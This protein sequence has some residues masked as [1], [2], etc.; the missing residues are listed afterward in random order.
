MPTGFLKTRTGT[1]VL[2]LAALALI[3]LGWQLAWAAQVFP[4]AVVP[5]PLSVAIAFAQLLGDSAFWTALGNTMLG[6]G[7]GLLVAI[8]VGIPLGMLTGR[9]WFAEKSLHFMLEFGRAFPAIAL[10]P[11]LV[12][13]IGTNNTM[14]SAVVFTAVLFPLVIQAQ[15]GARR[16]EPSIEETVRAFRI[17]R[18]KALAKIVLPSA[19]PFIATGIKLGATVSVLVALGVEVLAGVP[20]IGQELT[21]AQQSS[22][23]DFAF[24]YIFT[25]GILGFGVNAVVGLAKDRLIR[26]NAN[27]TED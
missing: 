6:A 18:S 16:I 9:A 19:A 10:L 15:H 11:V 13:I 17:P 23:S 26:W 7:Q 27:D 4:R 5:G 21:L 14:K 22:A 20:G 3:V 24:A 2:Q 1:A 12:L 25:A 8:L